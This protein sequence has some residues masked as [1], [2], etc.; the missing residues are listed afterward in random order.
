MLGRAH[1]VPGTELLA[2]LPVPL[3]GER[4]VPDDQAAQHHSGGGTE[5]RQQLQAQGSGFGAFAGCRVVADKGKNRQR[6]GRSDGHGKFGCKRP[7]REKP[8]GPVLA[9]FEPIDVDDVRLDRV[10]DDHRRPAQETGDCG[11][12]NL[13]VDG[14]GT[15][16]QVA[17]H[18]NR[19]RDQGNAP[20]SMFA[21]LF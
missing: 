14:A 7:H 16:K 11:D 2:D 5:H 8:G 17:E 12:R 15:E 10:G 6:D 20:C 3:F 4:K 21:N 1:L 18:Q 9:A 13:P 19:N